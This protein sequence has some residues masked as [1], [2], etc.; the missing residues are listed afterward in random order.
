MSPWR[1]PQDEDY[2]R[3]ANQSL[4]PQRISRPLGGFF[5]VV[6][7]VSLSA[8]LAVGVALTENRI[9]SLE[10]NVD[11]LRE[12]VT[13]SRQLPESGSQATKIVDLE[14]R[15]MK[16]EAVLNQQNASVRGI[17]E[18]LSIVKTQAE[19]INVN[20][21]RLDNR[22]AKIEGRIIRLEDATR[23]APLKTPPQGKAP[24]QGD[25]NG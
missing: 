12:I 21:S 4:S 9:Q 17:Q 15:V 18:G 1:S 2:E 10:N 3:P 14:N 19:A 11:K 22:T 6:L 7:T 24:A 8:S 23:K 13:N 5:F 16:L 20:L 25:P